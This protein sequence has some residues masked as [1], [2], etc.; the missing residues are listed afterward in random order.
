MKF[1]P[2]QLMRILD[3]KSLFNSI[4]LDEVIDICFTELFP[5]MNTFQNLNTNDLREL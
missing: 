5:D 3:V 2:E 4:P 1:C